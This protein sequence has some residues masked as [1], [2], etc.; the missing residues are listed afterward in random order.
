MLAQALIACLRYEFS[1]I[2]GCGDLNRELFIRRG[3]RDL[4]DR[5]A[6]GG[7]RIAVGL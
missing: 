2:Q 1:R 4:L 7:I 3:Q 6:D 5:F